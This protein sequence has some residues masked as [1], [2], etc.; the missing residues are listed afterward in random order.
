MDSADG[1]VC[2]GGI[3]QTNE[4]SDVAMLRGYSSHPAPDP[5]GSLAGASPES[6]RSTSVSLTEVL[7]RDYGETTVRLRRCQR[8]VGDAAAPRH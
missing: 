3:H 1:I 2:R 7:W 4:K 8:G 5:P 6:R